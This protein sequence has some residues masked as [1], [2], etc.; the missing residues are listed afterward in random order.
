MVNMNLTPE[1]LE[2]EKKYLEEVMKVV[3]EL[4]D[5]NSDSIDSQIDSIQEL[6]K[7]IWDNISELDDMEVAGEMYN[8]NTNVGY[9]NKRIANL[10]Q[11]RKSLYSPYFGRIDFKRDKGRSNKP[12]KIYIGLNGISKDMNHF[13]FDWR[14]PIAS[15]FYNYGIGNAS[16]EA[17]AGTINGEVTLKRQYKIANGQLERC[18]ESDL[19]I[20]DEY[21]QEILSNASSEKMT[22]IVKTIQKEQNVIIRNV[23]DKYL[24]VQGI[25]G[26]GKTSVALH[27]I[28]YLL[29]AEKNLTSNNV[30]IFSPNDVFS[31][32]I[33][34]ALPELGEDNVLQTTFSD[35]SKS[36]IKD[37]KNIESFT[38]FIERYYKN[39]DFDEE[40]FRIIKYKL[41]NEFK[42][43]LDEAI[44]A[45]KNSLSFNHGF[46]INDKFISKGEL[47]QM[48]NEKLS[49]LPIP[50][51]FDVLAENLCDICG[52]PYKKYEKTIKKHLLEM[53]SGQLSIKDL[54]VSILNSDNFKQKVGVSKELELKKGKKLMFEDLLPLLYINFEIN[55]Y[56]RGNS[57]KH[58]IIDEAQD[59]TELQISMLK[60][61]FTKASFTILGDV[62][63]TINPYYMYNSLDEMNS[64]FDNEGRYVELNKTY[65]SSEEII[66]YTNSILGINNACSVRKS[67]SIPVTVEN[68]ESYDL[69]K[70]LKLEIDRM[71]SIGLKRVAI[72]TKNNAQTLDIYSKLE[73]EVEGI[74]LI[75]GT[76]EQKI[77][78]IVVL[79]SYISK[80][81]EFD[82]VIVYTDDEHRYND[83]DK[84][85]FYVVCTRAQHC[86]TIFNQKTLKKTIN[87]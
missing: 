52:V 58:I 42:E 49:R 63:Q 83:K 66:D 70:K 1:Q 80:G 28:A 60:K 72:I 64:I 6:K 12:R 38:E 8:V 32:Y 59:Y 56:P 25:A 67:N 39:E 16:Y 20:D 86:L 82:G 21:L 11:L 30:L 61:I 24:I 68:V 81:L 23:V 47:N 55:G 19:N 33:S 43:N 36:Y 7:Y 15:L 13:V 22:N 17:P 34:N 41:S 14:T 3:K 2:E 9:A 31:E 35:F 40:E 84:Y 18:F 45:Y 69:V 26:S 48:F 75:D 65:R 10:Q 50:E 71:T 85:L 44:A 77:G 62:N 76:S 5:K 37:Y 53:I 4:Y 87:K 79:P 73:N 54:Y 78:R 46:T 29:Y 27:R 74:S 57:I 51:R